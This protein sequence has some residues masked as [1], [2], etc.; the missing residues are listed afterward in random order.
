MRR[1]K[2][3]ITQRQTTLDAVRHAGRRWPLLTRVL[4]LCLIGCL[5]ASCQ[6][7]PQY[8]PNDRLVSELGIERARQRLKDTL[9]RSINPQ[10]VD[11]EVTDDYFAYRFRQAIAGFQTGAVLDNRVFFLNAVNVQVLSNNVVNVFTS[12]QQLIAQLVFGNYEDARTVG[13][14]ITSFRLRK[15]ATR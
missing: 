12:N 7:T 1:H 10:V 14:L 2:V 8:I 9:V 11:T 15:S 3:G 13:D 5:S 4:F 6:S